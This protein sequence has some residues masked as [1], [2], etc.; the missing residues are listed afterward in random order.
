LPAASFILA[1][2]FDLGSNV[3]EAFVVHSEQSGTQSSRQSEV[4]LPVG[5]RASGSTCGIKASGKSDLALFVSDKSA[6]AA[7]VFTQNQ[8][9]GAPVTV[10]RERVPSS[11]VRGVV[12]NSGNSNACT[13]QPGIQDAQKMTAGVAAALGCDAEAVLVCSTGVIGVPLPL[14]RIQAGIPV[15]VQSLASTPQALRDAATAIMTTDT[16]AKI[17]GVDVHLR[18]GTI[19]VSGVAKGAAMI[20]PN[21]ATMLC[22]VMTDA[23]LSPSQCDTVLRYSVERTFNCVTVD[24]HTSTSDTVLL[25]ANGAAG[26]LC[27][28]PG[29]LEKIRDGVKLVCQHLSTDIIRDAE[30]ADH[31]I[32]I[33]VR[34]L[35]TRHAACR[36]ARE[37]S[38]SALVKTAIAGGDPNWG[39]IV[40]AAGYAG[41]EFDTSFVSLKINGTEVYRA[42]T[43]VPFLASELSS[44]LKSQREVH[45]ELTV[46]GGPSSGSEEARFWT[47]DLTCE[48]V[49]LNSEYTT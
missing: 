8:V 34:G 5:F 22:V 9:C 1:G 16:F 28:S 41:V 38:E 13:G 12:I 46:S 19:R 47:S 29:D 7:G 15:A 31:F 30:G 23:E 10:S 14:E 4:S 45:I 3:E 37:I 43:P 24:G 2:R 39:R 21:M 48:Y 40:S 42:G 20:A 49:R 36:I 27:D 33:D 6:A 35:A 18:Q 32:T 44:Q 17:T 11:A 26:V 25:L